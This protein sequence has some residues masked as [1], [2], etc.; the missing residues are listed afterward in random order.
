MKS[1]FALISDLVFSTLTTFL[2]LSVLFG[3]FIIYPFSIILSLTGTAIFLLFISK[4]ALV[5][6]KKGLKEQKR[7][8]EK[9]QT[10]NALNLMCKSD[11]FSLFSRAIKEKDYQVVDKDYALYLPEKNT[12]IFLFF[13]FMQVKK[14]DVL[15]AYNLDRTKKIAILSSEF[16]AEIRDFALKFGDKITL[17]DGEKI[18]DLLKETSLLPKVEETKER[19]EKPPF[20]ETIMELVKKVNTKKFFIFGITFLFFSYFA[21]IKSYYLL[22]GCIFLIISLLSKISSLSQ[23]D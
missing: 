3:Y 8:Q 9:D 17:C 20:R 5:K 22:C 4:L 12:L 7:E 2:I 21:P 6:Y 13:E 15:R 11:L 14:V 19:I 23:K 10:L 1:Y 16:S 18:Y